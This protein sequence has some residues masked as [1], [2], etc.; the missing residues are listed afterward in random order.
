L[1]NHF[2]G[3]P[4]EVDFHSLKYHIAYWFYVL[5]LQMSMCHNWSKHSSIFKQLR[6]SCWHCWIVVC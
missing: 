3:I 5:W 4:L 6:F 2:Q 1:K